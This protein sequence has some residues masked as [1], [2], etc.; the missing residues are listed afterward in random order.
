LDRFH[1]NNKE[2]LQMK[3]ETGLKAGQITVGAGSFVATN[4]Q[5]SLL[6]N[7][8]IGIA[9]TESGAA[10]SG[11]VSYSGNVVNNAN[12]SNLFSA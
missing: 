12:G 10:T 2:G 4:N 7:N 6:V 5:G 1:K 8:A 9:L 11:A 3:V